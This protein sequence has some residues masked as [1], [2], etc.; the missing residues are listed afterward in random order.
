MHLVADAERPQRR[1]AQV[2][3]HGRGRVGCVGDG[4][5][6][7]RRAPAR[8]D[9]VRACGALSARPRAAG[10]AAERRC[11]PRHVRLPH[12][13]V[14]SVGDAVALPHRDRRRARARRPRARGVRVSLPRGR[15]ELRALPRAPHDLPGGL[16]RRLRLLAGALERPRRAGAPRARRPAAGGGGNARESARTR[17]GGVHARPC[18]AAVLVGGKPEPDRLLGRSTSR[19]W[20]WLL[21]TCTGL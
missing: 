10:G 12:R 13:P 4:L 8:L 16:P 6:R 17:A 2:D 21:S 9:A 1:Q 14:P 3:P 11:R 15:D 5:P 7:R 18:A 19:G 20:G